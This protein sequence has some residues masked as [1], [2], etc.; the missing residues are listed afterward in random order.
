MA[1]KSELDK[2][3][4]IGPGGDTGAERAMYSVIPARTDG[5]WT[6]MSMCVCV[7]WLCLGTAD[8]QW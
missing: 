8:G 6:G 3:I 2:Q 7:Q 4:V 1:S 5:L